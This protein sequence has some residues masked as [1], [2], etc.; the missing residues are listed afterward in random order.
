MDFVYGPWKDGIRPEYTI[1]EYCG[2]Q[3]TGKSTLMVADLMNKLLNPDWD[4]GYK[5]EDVFCNFPLYIDGVH[6]LNNQRMK[7][8]LLYAKENKWTHKVFMVDECSQPPLFYAR[9]TRDVTQTELV[10]YLW[11]VPKLGNTFQY[12]SN[13][14]NSVDVQQRDA[15]WFTVMPMWYEHS[16]NREEEKIVYRAWHNYEIWEIE[17]EYLYP[18]ETQHWFSSFAPVR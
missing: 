8:C 16:E 15:T 13:V 4:F 1:V 11:Q 14:G 10:T 9:N 6:V 17:E 18:A 2:I 12:S 3:R 7:D 5:P